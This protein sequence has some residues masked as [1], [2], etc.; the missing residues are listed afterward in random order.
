M[1]RKDIK[2][3]TLNKDGYNLDSIKKRK[4]LVDEDNETLSSDITT[5]LPETESEIT[6]IPSIEPEIEPEEPKQAEIT[7]TM[8]VLS[9]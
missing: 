3:F 4:L 2:T 7:S 8:S 1:K 5:S 9:L 6:E